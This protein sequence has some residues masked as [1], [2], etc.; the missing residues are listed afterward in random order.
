[1]VGVAGSN[2]IGSNAFSTPET[3]LWP[4]TGARCRCAPSVK[5]TPLLWPGPLDPAKRDLEEWWCA[6]RRLNPV[7]YKSSEC[8]GSY[9]LFAFFHLA[10]RA[11]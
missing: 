6:T 4:P 7:H 1:M 5:Q 3:R 10:Q 2:S 11:L 9:F 8:Q